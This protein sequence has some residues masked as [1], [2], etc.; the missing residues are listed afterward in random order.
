MKLQDRSKQ[1]RGVDTRRFFTLLSL[2]LDLIYVCV[3]W[4]RWLRPQSV[5]RHLNG[6]VRPPYHSH[7]RRTRNSAV[8]VNDAL[9]LQNIHK[10]GRLTSRCL[11]VEGMNGVAHITSVIC[12]KPH[13]DLLSIVVAIIAEW[14]YWWHRPSIPKRCP[15]QTVETLPVHTWQDLCR[16]AGQDFLQQHTQQMRWG[17]LL[18][19]QQVVNRVCCLT[20]IPM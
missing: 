13:Q 6:R 15:L 1:K 7:G 19:K 4:L 18:S 3:R 2:R 10:R 17:D 11:I 16:H 14:P 20:L 9:N 5:K 12:P 8:C